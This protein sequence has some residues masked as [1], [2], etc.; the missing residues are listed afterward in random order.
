MN[1]MTVFQNPDFGNLGV[2]YENDKAYF[3]ATECAKMLG[4]ENPHDAITRHCPHLVKREVGVQTGVKADGTPAMQ[5]VQRSYIPEGDL[6][7]LIIRSKLPSAERFEKWV[8]DEVLPTLRK[9]G[10]YGK[11]KPVDKNLGNV[12]RLMELTRNAMKE[13]KANP[14]DICIAL[15]K[16]A[17]DNGVFLPECFVQ[18]KGASIDEL[19]SMVDYIYSQPR[20]RG[21]R[22]P[23]YED[24][25]THTAEQK[26]LPGA[27][28]EKLIAGDEMTEIII[29][30]TRRKPSEE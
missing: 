20:G 19:L 22:V 18:D 8:F 24:W 17:D 25:L 30:R 7:R 28:A 21:K 16:I 5:A 11:R 26:A 27:E 15:K 13:T 6:Y 12:V 9:T 23:T 2:I 29:R 1:Q 14:H 10:Y 4:Y 3:P